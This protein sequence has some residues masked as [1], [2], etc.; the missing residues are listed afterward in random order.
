MT[1]CFACARSIAP[2]QLPESASRFRLHHPDVRFDGCFADISLHA[3]I[4]IDA[5]R[6]VIRMCR[7][8]VE[9]LPPAAISPTLPIHERT[10]AIMPSDPNAARKSSN[11]MLISSSPTA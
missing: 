9:L 1:P 6:R 11:P 8:K 3:K 4:H 5:V 10:N 2:I 7:N